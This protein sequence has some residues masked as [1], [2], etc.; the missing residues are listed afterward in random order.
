MISKRDCFTRGPTQAGWNPTNGWIKC[1][2]QFIYKY[3]TLIAIKI[4]SIFE[5]NFIRIESYY[6]QLTVANG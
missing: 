1:N 5:Y 6:V 2:E 4:E 3:V